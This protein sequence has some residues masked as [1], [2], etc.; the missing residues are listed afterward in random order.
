MNVANMSA[1][2]R[3]SLVVIALIEAAQG[4]GLPQERAEAVYSEL[5]ERYGMMRDGFAQALLHELER[6]IHM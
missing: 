2:N 1:E 6:I 4:A 3:V 5:H